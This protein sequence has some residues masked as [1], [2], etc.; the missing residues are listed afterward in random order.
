MTHFYLFIID[1]L[2]NRFLLLNVDRIRQYPLLY[3]FIT[4]EV[5]TVCICYIK[6]KSFISMNSQQYRELDK[7]ELGAG[8]NLV[9][10]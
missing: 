8:N 10:G 4:L 5:E 6:S 7:K 9:E 1:N 3:G 2:T